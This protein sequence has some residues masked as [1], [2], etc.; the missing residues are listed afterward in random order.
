MKLCSKC[1]YE[2]PNE[3]FWCEECNAKLVNPP[4]NSK[5]ISN[6]E[7]KI[8]RD[9]LEYEYLH[10]DVSKKIGKL[11]AVFIVIFIILSA[12]VII[13][14]TLNKGSDFEGINSVI[15]EDYWFEGNN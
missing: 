5:K 9:D 7:E 3:A 15:N 8:E 4:R 11:F 1:G 6:N 10:N 13:Y 2:N 14:F 12:F